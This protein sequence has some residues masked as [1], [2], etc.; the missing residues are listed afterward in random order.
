VSAYQPDQDRGSLG[1]WFPTFPASAF[2]APGHR[3]Y[4]PLRL[5]MARLGV[6]RV[7]LSSPDTSYRAS[8]FVSL[9]HPGSCE[10]RAPPLHAGRLHLGSA[11]LDLI[12]RK[13]TIGS[14][15]FPSHPYRYMPRS[16][17]PVVPCTL[18]LAP[19]GLLPSGH[20]IP[21]AFPRYRLR[22]I[23]WTTTLHISG[24]NH[25]ASILVP[26][27]FALPLLGVHV[28]VTPD[29]LA[30]LWSGGTC[31]LSVRTHWVTTTNFMG[32]LPVPRFRAY[33]GTSSAVLD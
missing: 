8:C 31:T 27:S 28:D 7:S 15:T 12:L 23:L 33:L 14:P 9:A 21:S 10:R 29:L 22:S 11:L 4:D 30:R 19:P 2:L 32:F 24:L 17:T 13:E 26:S 18:A 3:Y 20:C 1:R 16:Q 25:A 6:V 5:P